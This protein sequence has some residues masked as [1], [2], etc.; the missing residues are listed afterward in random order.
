MRK[1]RFGLFYNSL[2]SLTLFGLFCGASCA[3]FQPFWP[4]MESFYSTTSTPT[5]M[6]SSHFSTSLMASQSSTAYL[7]WPGMPKAGEEAPISVAQ[8]PI[9]QTTSFMNYSNYPPWR[10]RC[11]S[12]WLRNPLKMVLQTLKEGVEQPQITIIMTQ[13][14]SCC[15]RRAATIRKTCSLQLSTN[16]LIMKNS[17]KSDTNQLTINSN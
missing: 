10:I 4:L 1:R 15:Q 6:Q 12:W 17:M 14:W 8:P 16:N 13:W 2:Y 7:M 3:I 5:A 11:N 9:N